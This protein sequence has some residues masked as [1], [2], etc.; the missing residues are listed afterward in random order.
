[1]WGLGRRGG[2]QFF[3]LM[4]GPDPDRWPVAA[5]F[6]SMRQWDLFEGGFVEFLLAAVTKQHP[7]HGDIVPGGMKEVDDGRAYRFGGDWSK[8]LLE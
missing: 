7:Y 1:M 3:W 2:D 8:Q 4:R 5:K 6:D